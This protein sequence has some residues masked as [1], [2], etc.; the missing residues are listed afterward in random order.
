MR[1]MRAPLKPLEVNSTTAALRI[2]ARVRSGS[3]GPER[4][5]RDCVLL[6][7]ASIGASQN[8]AGRRNGASRRRPFLRFRLLSENVVAPDDDE[9]LGGVFQKI[10]RGGIGAVRHV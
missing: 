3:L 4:R 8:P 9:V 6:T 1:S 7:R 10:K 2:T 5:R